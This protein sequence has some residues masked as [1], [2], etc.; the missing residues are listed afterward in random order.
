[1]IVPDPTATARLPHPSIRRTYQQD[2]PIR[3]G[4]QLFD[5]Q[6]DERGNEARVTFAPQASIVEIPHREDYSRPS[7]HAQWASSHETRQTAWRNAMEV[8]SEG[9]PANWRNFKDDDQLVEYPPGSDNYIHPYSYWMVTG[10]A[11][12]GK[13]RRFMEE[14]K[15][16]MEEKR[17]KKLS[18]KI[19]K[20]VSGL[21]FR[22]RLC[23]VVACE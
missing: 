11:P 19:Q 21:F 3:Q 7:R 9:G 5:E 2:L 18:Y 20:A 22:R 17:Q 23:R 15:R 8:R 1:M 6:S 12:Y 4:I 14:T 13:S 10:L 16:F